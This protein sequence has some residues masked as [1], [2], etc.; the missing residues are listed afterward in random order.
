[1]GV[2]ECRIFQATP[3]FGVVMLTIRI[4]GFE[5]AE[6]QIR[7]H[8]GRCITDWDKTGTWECFVDFKR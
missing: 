2:D 7:E 1:L 4:S 3:R 6:K 8:I 5:E